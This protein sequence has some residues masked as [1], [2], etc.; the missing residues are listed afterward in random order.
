MNES[1]S[2][3][4]LKIWI[5]LLVFGA[6]FAA[7]ANTLENEFVF[8]DQAL[9]TQNPEVKN[10]DLPEILSLRGYRPLRTLTYAINYAVGGT[11]PYGYHLFNVT[12]HALNAVLVLGV[13][14]TWKRSMIVAG[15]G[16]LLFALHP[17]Q[18]AAVAYVSGRKDQMAVFFVLLG[19]Y[20]FT[21]YRQTGKKH[22]S[23]FSLL[24][25]CLGVLSKEVAIVF[26]AL[27]LVL[28]AIFWARESDEQARP[29]LFKSLLR[30]LRR[31]PLFYGAF[32]V[33]GCLAI[34]YAVFITQASRKVGLWGGGL[35]AHFGT[36][37]KLFVHYLRLALVP[38]ALRA[39]YSAVFPISP[40]F[41]EPLTL[42]SVGVLVAYLCLAVW[43]FGRERLVSLGMLWFLIALLPVL[44]IVPFH[45]IAA[46]HFLYFPL[47]GMALI[48]GRGTEYLVR[49]S[50]WRKPVWTLVAAVFLTFTIATV[51]RNRDWK[52]PQSLW[53]ATL[54][55]APG[56]FRANNNLASIYARQG[57]WKRAIELTRRSIQLDPTQS[58]P[59]NNLGTIYQTLGRKARLDGDIHTAISLNHEGIEFLNKAVQLNP[60]DPFALNSL[61][62]CYKE[63]ANI[64]EYQ[65]YLQATQ[66]ARK[67]AIDYFLQALSMPSEHEMIS[68]ISFNAAMVYID[69]GQYDQ[70]LHH[71]QAALNDPMT[72]PNLAD[73]QYWTG[74]CYYRTDNHQ[75]AAGHLEEALRLA[76]HAAWAAQARHMLKTLNP[77]ASGLY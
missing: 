25:F 8:D 46:D 59:W 23:I 76:P 35:E 19:C 57:D 65:G 36:S 39:D 74:Y 3:E 70:A 20:L 60:Q 16:A 75:R 72:L 21:R 5:I 50:K 30:A 41:S 17:V 34:Y 66:K 22:L 63:L 54:E 48:A 69:A 44:Q 53:E 6:A 55:D 13:F 24:S 33:L 77:Q 11:N 7:Y 12:L 43:L 38:Y 45:E 28:D 47:I 37:F 2:P 58:E 52:T 9:I 40:G 64:W 18:T 14:W 42:M 4:R 27:L 29:S 56:S 51:D 31:S 1:G 73:A 10:L 62:S 32:V 15:T 61:A 71:L 26:P 68:S 49:S 67:K